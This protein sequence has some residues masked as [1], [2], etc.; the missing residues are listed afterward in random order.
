MAQLKTLPLLQDAKFI[1]ID[2]GNLQFSIY[3]YYFCVISIMEFINNYK[4]SVFM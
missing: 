4:Y 1:V 3:L 2:E